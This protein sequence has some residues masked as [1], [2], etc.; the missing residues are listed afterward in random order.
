MFKS[1]RKNGTCGSY[2]TAEEILCNYNRSMTIIILYN[3]Y[4][5]FNTGI[6]KG[7][8]Y[9]KVKSVHDFVF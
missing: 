2:S 1:M 8:E 6:I 3:Q 5:Q 7:N 4:F 9:G